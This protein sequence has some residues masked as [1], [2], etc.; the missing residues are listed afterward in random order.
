[1]TGS[2][3]NGSVYVVGGRCTTVGSATPFKGTT[4]NQKL[5]CL[6]VPDRHPQR[7]RFIDFSAGGLMAYSIRVKPL[8]SRS[9]CGTLAGQVSSARRLN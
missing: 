6:N 9:A 8:R 4:D 7:W 2:V 5:L 1:M 3:L